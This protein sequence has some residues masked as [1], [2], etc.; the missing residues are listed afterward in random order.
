MTP[1]LIGCREAIASVIAQWCS[2]WELICVNNGSTQACIEEI[3]NE[4]IRSES[5]IKVVTLAKNAGI[6][7][8]VNAGMNASSGEL[9]AWMDHDDYLEPDA[10][11][12]FLQ[13][14]RATN[15]DLLYCDELIT[16]Q[17]L[18]CIRYVAARPAY[19]WDYYLAHPYFVH[20]VCVTRSLLNKVKGWNESMPVSGDVDFILRCQEHAKLVAHIPSVLYRWR[21]HSGSAGHQMKDFVTSAT[22]A[23]LNRHLARTTPGAVATAGL[24]FNFYRIH[25]PD[26][27]GKV[28]VVI[29]IK[30]EGQLLKLCLES[31]F[32]TTQSA[33]VD[34]VVLITNLT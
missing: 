32:A 29:P 30:N 10:V 11:Y 2:H 26:D 27:H 31:I 5:R 18:D 15:A 1:R 12:K 19:S 8:G 9:I 28:L 20:M 13:A 24:G 23:A 14:Y 17:N 7:G 34:I 6:A 21:T 3:L 16:D 4:Y 33:E 22:L 25:F